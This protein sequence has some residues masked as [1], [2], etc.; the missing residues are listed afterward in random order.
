MDFINSNFESC[1]FINL[2]FKFTNF[3]SCTFVNCDFSGSLFESAGFS[4]CSF[5]ETKLSYIDLGTVSIFNCNF[6]KAVAENCIFQKLKIGS[7]TE[8]LTLD[9][10]SCNFRESNLKGS[11]FVKCNLAK[12][13]FD[14]ANLENTVFESCNLE[15]ADLT[16]TKI[17]GAGF[18]NCRVKKTYLD[19]N[20]FIDFGSSQGFVL[21]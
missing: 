19:V 21:K 1:K 18:V 13:V 12:T 17:A 11:I 20:G 14:L 10:R 9:L 2:T 3:E 5:P 15:E 8:R 7:K 6:H 16:E 4:G